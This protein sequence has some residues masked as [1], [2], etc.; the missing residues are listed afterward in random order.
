MKNLIRVQD[1]DGLKKAIEG[2]Q[3]YWLFKHSSTC[4]VSAAAWNEYNEYCSL[5]P[6]QTFLFLVVQEDKELSQEI[7]EITQIKHESP[8]LMHFS[9]M[10]V[11]W[12]ASHNKIKSKAMQEFIA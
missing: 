9:N 6:H 11:D 1:L 8:Q 12:H 10:Q 7:A 5:H 2:T 3:S 4:P